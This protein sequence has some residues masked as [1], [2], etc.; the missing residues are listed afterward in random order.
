LQQQTKFLDSRPQPQNGQRL[1]IIVTMSIVAPNSPICLTSFGSDI[2]VAKV[3]TLNRLVSK[4]KIPQGEELAL[5][6]KLQRGVQFD[7]MT[8][9]SR[10]HPSDS[11]LLTPRIG[12][13]LTHGFQGGA[14]G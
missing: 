12:Q 5:R 4:I 3:L 2:S 1:L 10:H 11:C 6:Q 13:G 9:R 7:Q 8:R 14:L